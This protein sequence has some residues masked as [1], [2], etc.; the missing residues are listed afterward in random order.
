MEMPMRLAALILAALVL[1]GCGQTAANTGPPPS[2]EAP[3][4]RRT[5]ATGEMCDGFAGIACRAPGDFCKH[6]AGQ[7]RTADGAGTCTPKPQFC[8]RQY[9]PVCGCDGK[10]YGNACEADAAGAQVDHTGECAKAG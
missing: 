7:C 2:G 8:T 9:A 6:P 10:T 3:A 5:A 1:A 4:P